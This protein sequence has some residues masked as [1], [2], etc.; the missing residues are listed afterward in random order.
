MD[1]TQTHFVTSFFDL[2]D[3]GHTI[4]RIVQRTKIQSALMMDD[5]FSPLEGGNGMWRNLFFFSFWKKLSRYMER[6]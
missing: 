3:G 6:Q 1:Y 2:N 4:K 5:F